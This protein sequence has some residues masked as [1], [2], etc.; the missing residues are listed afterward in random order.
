MLSSLNE[1][2][3]RDFRSVNNY[4]FFIWQIVFICMVKVEPY[5]SSLVTI[6]WPPSFSMM[7]LQIDKPSPLPAGLISWCPSR[8]PKAENKLFSFSVGMP[9]PKS[10]M[11][12]LNAICFSDRLEL[13]IEISSD[14]P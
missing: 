9:T 8:V 1:P 10:R 7:V 12:S 11:L 2:S 4:C 5:P 14:G 3:I 13:L 6:I